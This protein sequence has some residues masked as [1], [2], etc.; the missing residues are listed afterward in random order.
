MV[1]SEKKM[2]NGREGML[3]Q[4]SFGCGYGSDTE[5]IKS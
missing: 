2:L 1:V 4:G 3:G 5:L